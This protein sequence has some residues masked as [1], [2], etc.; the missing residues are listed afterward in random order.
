[1]SKDIYLLYVRNWL[2]SN[3]NKMYLDFNRV[4]INRKTI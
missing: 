4:F 1:M 2:V 3:E